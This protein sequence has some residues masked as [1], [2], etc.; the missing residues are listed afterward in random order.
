MKAKKVISPTKDMKSTLKI[1]L[2]DIKTVYKPCTSLI[3]QGRH[4]SLALINFTN[5]IKTRKAM[6][7]LCLVD[8]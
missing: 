5:I 1:K 6:M 2:K 3:Y 7:S 4:P 8:K